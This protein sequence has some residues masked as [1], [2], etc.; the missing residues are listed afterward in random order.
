MKPFQNAGW[1]YYDQVWNILP[2]IDTRGSHAFSTL[3][4]ASVSADSFEETSSAEFTDDKS[5][6]SEVSRK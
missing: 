4:A 5:K 1:E 2:D 3:N 6:F